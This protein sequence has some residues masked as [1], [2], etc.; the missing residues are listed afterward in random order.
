M[1]TTSLIKVVFVPLATAWCTVALADLSVM[2]GRALLT[3]RQASGGSQAF[4]PVPETGYGTTC[5]QTFGAGYIQ[6]AIYQGRPNCYNPGDGDSCCREGC[7]FKLSLFEHALI[8][9]KVIALLTNV[10]TF[11]HMPW[12]KF[13]SHSRLLLSRGMC[14]IRETAYEGRVCN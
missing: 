7:M 12:R 5:E 2:Q 14:S 8:S 6:C 9:L 1:H 4:K 10:S 3:K 13:L 11:R